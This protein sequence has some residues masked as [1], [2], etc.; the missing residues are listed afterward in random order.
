MGK[1]KK[2]VI[3]IGIAFAALIGLSILAALITNDIPSIDSNTLESSPST[4]IVSTQI[5]Q[6]SS[7]SNISTKSVLDILPTRD[8]IGTEWRISPLSYNN[9]NLE[10]GHLGNSNTVPKVDG[11]NAIPIGYE[12]QV[13]QNYTTDSVMRVVIATFDS[14]ND[15]NSYYN[16]ITTKLYEKGGFKQIDTSS[17]GAKCFSVFRELDLSTISELYCVKENVYYIVKENGGFAAYN[18]DVKETTIKFAKIIANKIDSRLASAQQLGSLSLITF[19]EKL[20]KGDE[21]CTTTLALANNDISACNALTNNNYCV[22]SY[23]IK[24]NEPKDCTVATDSL[25]CFKTVSLSLGSHVCTFTGNEKDRLECG[26]SYIANAR[27]VDHYSSDRIRNVCLSTFPMS[28]HVVLQNT[29][30]IEQLNLEDISKTDLLGWKTG[31]ELTI[32]SRLDL[33][34][35][36]EKKDDYCLSSVGVYLKDLSICDQAGDARAECYGFIALTEDFVDLDTCDRLDEGRSFCYMHVAYR[37]DDI[38]I[39]DIADSNKENCIRLVNS[40]NT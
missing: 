31:N 33:N 14:E 39:C 22:S 18:E 19:G 21:D 28:S 12:D 17:I 1:G 27:L 29:C 36:W 26:E 9:T 23:A 10:K 7:F 6:E 3:G 20:C 5:D 34:A 38:S 30:K 16:S 35:V 13:A 4:P 32:C 8:D 24:F 15:A 25:A 37:L 11:S 40:W 2:I